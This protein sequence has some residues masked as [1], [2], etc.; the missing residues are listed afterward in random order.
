MEFKIFQ[1][2]D[3][4]ECMYSFMCFDFA[5]RHGFCRDDYKL[6]YTFGESS[7]LSGDISGKQNEELLEIIFRRFNRVT[8]D[9]VDR[10]EF[11]GFKGRSLST[12]DV[13]KID[14]EY[15]YCDDCGWRNVTEVF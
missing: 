9:D 10:L 1:I 14:N 6:V 15:Y 5:I 11:I 4:H 2:K 8:Q 7:L 13:V 12:S 3:L